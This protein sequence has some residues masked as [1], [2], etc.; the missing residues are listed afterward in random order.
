MGVGMD[1]DKF[2]LLV[3]VLKI[4]ERHN[5][6]DPEIVGCCLDIID[7]WD[8]ELTAEQKAAVLKEFLHFKKKKEY[9]RNRFEEEDYRQQMQDFLRPRDLIF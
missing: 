7:N 1:T 4:L 6:D 3:N 9:E 2:E 5:P 8:D